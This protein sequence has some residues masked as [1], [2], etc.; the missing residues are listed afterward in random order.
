MMAIS[1]KISALLYR[2]FINEN[3]TN[4]INC[5]IIRFVKVQYADMAE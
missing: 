2:I 4:L 5:D 1:L 3:L